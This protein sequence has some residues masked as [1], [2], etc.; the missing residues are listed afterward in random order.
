MLR[1]LNSLKGFSL[2][3]R[4]GAFGKVDD[5]YFD[6]ATWSIRYLVANTGGWLTGRL[7]LLS[8][9]ALQ[10]PDFARHSLPVRLT[11]EQIEK[12][13]PIH[14][15]KPVSRQQEEELAR[16]YQWPYYWSGTGFGTVAGYT[17]VGVIPIE[18][19]VPR[20]ERQPTGDPHLRSA[21][22]VRGYTI[23]A[24]DG[25]IGSIDDLILD[26]DGWVIRY[27]VVDTTRWRPGGHVLLALEWVE[28]I[29]WENH[30]GRT[31]LSREQ[32]RQSPPYHPDKVLNRDDETVLHEHY[33][34]PAYWRETSK[35]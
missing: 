2:D 13:P 30:A 22:E 19:A 34:K 1:N 10:E 4:D 12:S 33:G 9:V 5:F 7:V 21:N 14:A 20:A 11:K 18:P 15:H 17:G 24:K 28:R 23:A 31:S 26:D 35:R 3:A 25:D 8:P 29:E 6:D 32:V 16:Y 27:L